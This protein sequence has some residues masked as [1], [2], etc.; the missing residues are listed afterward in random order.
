MKGLNQITEIYICKSLERRNERNPKLAS[1]VSGKTGE[2]GGRAEGRGEGSGRGKG[3]R[4][5]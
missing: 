4:R 3:G 1:D 5:L 2:W